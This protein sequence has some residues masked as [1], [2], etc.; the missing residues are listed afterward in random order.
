MAI[1]KIQ[2]GNGTPQEV[3]DAKALHYIGHATAGITESSGTYTSG[4]T[5][6]INSSPVEVAKYDYV[7]FG[8]DKFVHLPQ[9]LHQITAHG[10]NS[11]KRLLR[12][13]YWV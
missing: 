13:Q 12:F 7:T 11:Q 9:V 6:T 8:T 3:R 4:A 1:S 2:L 5:V 10:K